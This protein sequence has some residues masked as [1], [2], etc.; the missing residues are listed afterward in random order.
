MGERGRRKTEDGRQE[1]LDVAATAYKWPTTFFTLFSFT[2]GHRIGYKVRF[3][4]N[5]NPISNI[6]HPSTVVFFTDWNRHLFSPHHKTLEGCNCKAL[7]QWPKHPVILANNLNLY[8]PLFEKQTIIMDQPRVNEALKSIEPVAPPKGQGQ[9]TSLSSDLNSLSLHSSSSN[10]TACANISIDR[11]SRSS[12]IKFS[13]V[14][15]HHHE[16]ICGD[17]PSVSDGVPLQLD[18]N[19]NES[20][21]FDIDT[22]EKITSDDKQVRRLSAVERANIAGECNS[23]SFLEKV[24]AEVLLI[25]GSRQI[26]MTDKK[27]GRINV[28]S[29]RKQPEARRP[30]ALTSRGTEYTNWF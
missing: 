18:W 22:Y 19:R 15:V 25:Q 21:V 8:K 26:S 5:D 28:A 30:S 27:F 2:D 17:N 12:R 13:T 6:R 9:S 23:K 20:E 11:G 14:N 16:L 29:Y 7:F 3:S 1:K 4:P 10:D 24:Q